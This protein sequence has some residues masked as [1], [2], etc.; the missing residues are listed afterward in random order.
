M[1][2]RRNLLSALALACA[3]LSSLQAESISVAFASSPIALDPHHSYSSTEA[4]IYT[5]L[6]EGLYTYHPLTLEPVPGVAQFYEVS[7]D[8]LTYTFYLR[9]DARYWNGDPVT[10]EDFRESWL[11]HLDPED[12]AEYT[13]LLDVIEGA[14]AYRTGRGE[15]EEVGIRVTEAGHLQV[16]LNTPASHF[17]KMLCHHSFAPIHPKFREEADWLSVPSVIGNGPF[18]LYSRTEEKYVLRKSELYWDRDK[19]LSD[20]I[21]VYL[22]DEFERMTEMFN[23]KEILW[24]SG[25]ILYDRIDD[26]ETLAVFHQFATSYFYFVCDDEPWDDP[27]VRTALLKL[28]PWEKI[29]TE[30]RYAVPTARAVPSIAGYP[31]IQGINAA[32]REYAFELLAEAGYP[33][34]RGLPSPSFKIPE[35]QEV[36]ELASAM[37]AAWKEELGLD[38]RFIVI[39]YAA[40]YEAIETR[41]YTLGLMSWI[42]DYADPLAF[43]QM[44]V[45]DSNLNK[46]NYANPDYDRIIEE[47]MRL[48]G[49]E[50]YNRMAEAEELILAEGG[51]IPYKHSPSYNFVH[52]EV[53]S[54][55]V[56]NPLD[57]HPFKYLHYDKPPL[58]ARIVKG[59]P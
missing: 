37:A 36:R 24:S 21:I 43:L 35:S 2:M 31:E 4:Q 42:G 33:E 39:P 52:G 8:G 27:R 28:I 56:P 5:A 47:S 50:R 55:W 26:P 40:Y 38:T 9:P 13:F 30:E 19:V 32:D 23:T 16:K 48:E 34:G 58:P 20:E 41:D 59:A 25:N 57:I 44:W 18:M 15:R 53:L 10:A 46:G 11:L 1:R 54:G 51:I 7:E 14:R 45:S 49:R 6:Y 22:S 3:A 29:R 12:D 17:L